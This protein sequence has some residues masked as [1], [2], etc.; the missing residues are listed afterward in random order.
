MLRP[1]MVM[2]CGR[3]LG[4]GWV[5][6]PENRVIVG[7]CAAA[8]ED[9]FLGLCADQCG[10]LFAGGFDG[11]ACALAWGMDGGGVSKVGGEVGKHGVE[12]FGVD[13]G[14][15]VVIDIDAVHGAASM[16]LEA[17]GCP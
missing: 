5:D 2:G 12:D 4:E 1:Y 8:G 7:F 11:G 3:I 17:L 6:H 15:G 16:I 9:D 13:G 10:D 14:G